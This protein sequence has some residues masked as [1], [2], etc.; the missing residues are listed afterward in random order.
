[1]LLNFFTT[2]MS[3]NY[4]PVLDSEKDSIFRK[5]WV[6]INSYICTCLL[7]PDQL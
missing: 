4:I 7:N 1:M 3:R 2:K 6:Q 5:K